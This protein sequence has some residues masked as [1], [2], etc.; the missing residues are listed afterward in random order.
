M[1][2][3]PASRRDRRWSALDACF[4]ALLVGGAAAIVVGAAIVHP[5]AG[6]IT[7]GAFAIVAALRVLP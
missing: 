5:A 6:W 4:V 2:Q 3:A 7:G 1:A